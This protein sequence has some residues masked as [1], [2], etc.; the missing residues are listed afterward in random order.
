MVEMK[1]LG[2]GSSSVGVVRPATTGS[3]KYG[4]NLGISGVERDDISSH[5]ELEV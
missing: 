3:R 1:G 5:P 4:P 2:L